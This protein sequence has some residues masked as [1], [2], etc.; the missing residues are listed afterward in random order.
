MQKPNILVVDD[1]KDICMALR[2][3]LTKEGYNVKEAYNGEQAIE[4]IRAEVP[5][6]AEVDELIEFIRASER[7][8]HK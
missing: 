7:G 8:V 4:R 6:C 1:E 3:L 2:I 5:P